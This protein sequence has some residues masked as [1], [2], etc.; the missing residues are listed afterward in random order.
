MN[1]RRQESCPTPISGVFPV[2]RD[3]PET[4]S[5]GRGWIQRQSPA[6]RPC[7]GLFRNVADDCQAQAISYEF[8]NE[9]TR[10]SR[11]ETKEIRVQ[12]LRRN[13]NQTGSK[14]KSL[15]DAVDSVG[16]AAQPRALR[17]ERQHP[18]AARIIACGL[19]HDRVQASPGYDIRFE[20]HS[21]STM[22]DSTKAY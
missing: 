20:Y 12:T 5:A 19:C 16:A 17:G 3:R 1:L 7:A 6:S 2:L 11:S 21:D 22:K 8:L 9:L 13:D 18:Y 10:Y 4:I 15:A 14:A